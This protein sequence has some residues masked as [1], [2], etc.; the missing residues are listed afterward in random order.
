MIVIK[1]DFDWMREKIEK[2]LLADAQKLGRK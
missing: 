1:T 2:K